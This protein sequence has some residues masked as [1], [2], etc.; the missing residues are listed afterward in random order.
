M[1]GRSHKKRKKTDFSPNLASPNLATLK[2]EKRII[3]TKNAAI[4]KVPHVFRLIFIA[5]I[6]EM[7]VNY[8][9]RL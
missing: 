2:R 7:L 6:T 8:K 5:T 1:K 9:K 4:S 3:L